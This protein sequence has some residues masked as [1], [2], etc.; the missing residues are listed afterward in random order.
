MKTSFKICGLILA[1][2][3]FAACS[4]ET[5]SMSAQQPTPQPAPPTYDR[6]AEQKA[7]WITE[8]GGNS[9][10]DFNPQVDILFITDNSDS[11]KGAQANLVRNMDKFSDGILRN[12][13]IDYHIGVVSTWD[14]SERFATAKKDQ[15]GIGE[16]R[17]IKDSKN[18]S[19]N[20]RFVTRTEKDLMA[21]TLDIGV[22]PLAEG[23]PE[24]EEFLSPLLAALDKSGNGQVND[25]FFRSDAQ[26]VVIFLTDA[27][28]GSAS[29]TPE[30]VDRRLLDFKG[31]RKDKYS[32]YGVL[33]NAKDSDSYKDYGLRILPKYHSECYDMNK[34]TPARITNKSEPGCQIG[35]GPKRLE[36][37]IANANK[38][39]DLTNDDQI[40]GKYIMSIISRNF[41]TDLANI[42]ADIKVR[43]L[44]KEI[45]LTRGVPVVE[46]GVIQIR[47]RYGTPED[48]ALGKGQIIPQGKGGWLYNPD[49]NSV[50]LSGDVNYQYKEGAR[51]AV[52]LKAAILN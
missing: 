23:G 37:L 20:K 1:T 4:P 13:M 5:A 32:V 47:V 28:D 40:K 17:F 48:L 50:R 24:N 46:N 52:D 35:F 2:S 45:V 21:S 14:S 38:S 16:L 22:A 18:Q 31:G 49:Q 26:L 12:K 27:D 11:M 25:G 43:T 34:K 36:Q 7:V 41:G 44:A 33:V 15:Y 19:F 51:F 6:I 42:G 8:D 39:A 3:L 30:E 10:L 9:Q 29:I